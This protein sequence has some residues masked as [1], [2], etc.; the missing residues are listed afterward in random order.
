MPPHGEVNSPLPRQIDPLPTS[1]QPGERQG[2]R[3]GY[4]ARARRAGMDFGGEQRRF[5]DLVR[6][7]YPCCKP[8]AGAIALPEDSLKV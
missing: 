7:V 4:I 8:P 1:F 6:E 5:C 2:G 3:E